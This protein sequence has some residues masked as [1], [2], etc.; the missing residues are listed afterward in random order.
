MYENMALPKDSY[1]LSSVFITGES[2]KNMSNSTNIRKKFEIVSGL[3]GP[4]EVD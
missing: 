2:I 1:R 4:G 3:C